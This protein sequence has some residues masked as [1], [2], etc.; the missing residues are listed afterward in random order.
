VNSGLLSVRIYPQNL[1]PFLVAKIIFHVNR[2]AAVQAKIQLSHSGL[3]VFLFI[4]NKQDT[5]KSIIRIL[6]DWQ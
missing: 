6:G 4:S 5:L 2:L 3:T 1:K